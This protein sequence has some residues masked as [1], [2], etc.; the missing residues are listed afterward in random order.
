[1]TKLESTFV[2]G[3]QGAA[4]LG[5]GHRR[6]CEWELERIASRHDAALE[7]TEIQRHETRRY[8]RQVPG[9]TGDGCRRRYG[10]RT[11]VGVAKQ[12]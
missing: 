4:A 12:D 3:H 8:L 2:P 1:M 9:G 11:F 7:D 10:L 5:P 6:E